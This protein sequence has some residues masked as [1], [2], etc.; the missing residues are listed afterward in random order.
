MYKENSASI[1]QMKDNKAR[2]DREQLT[3]KRHTAYELISK[4]IAEVFTTTRNFGIKRVLFKIFCQVNKRVI[5]DKKTIYNKNDKSELKYQYSNNFGNDR[6][7]VYTAIFGGYDE[8]LEPSYISPICDYYV[9]TDYDIPK[10]SA[11]KKIDISNM[12]ELHG[13][14]AYHLSKY[15][16]M[17]PHAFFKDYKYSIWVDGATKIIADLAAFADRL[18]DKCIGMFDNPVHDCIYTEGN[19]LIYYNRVNKQDIKR[20]LRA[21][22]LEGYPKHNGM[23]ECTVIVRKHNEEICIQLM[24]MWWDQVNQYTMRD[25][26]SFPFVLWKNKMKNSDILCLGVNRNYNARLSFCPHKKLI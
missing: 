8:L 14:D 23:F 4:S 3:P 13:M 18:K 26:I 5:Y 6:I 19:Y 17:F 7:A 12:A 20:Q 9:F 15:I 16:K 2:I 21:Y 11:W 25:Q 10:D 1:A 24:N 22:Q